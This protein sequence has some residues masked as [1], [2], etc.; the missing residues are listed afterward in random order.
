MNQKETLGPLCVLWRTK[1]KEK[2]KINANITKSTKYF[3]QT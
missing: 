3:K 1:I 2:D